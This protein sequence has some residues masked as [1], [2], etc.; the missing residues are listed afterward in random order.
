MAKM[1]ICLVFF[2]FLK[3]D[4]TVVLEGR[5]FDRQGYRLW[6]VICSKPRVASDSIK[7]TPCVSWDLDICTPLFSS[8]RLLSGTQ[9]RQ[10]C[11]LSWMS[12]PCTANKP[13][14]YQKVTP[15]S[16][17]FF[18]FLRVLEGTPACSPTSEVEKIFQIPARLCKKKNKSN[19]WVF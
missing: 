2:Y 3:Q 13:N 9:L 5:L 7:P 10:C 11:Q 8:V 16:Q 6:R 19:E 17:P 12:T 4:R 18:L 15:F 14:V 1:A